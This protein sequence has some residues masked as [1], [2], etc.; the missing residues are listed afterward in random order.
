MRVVMLGL[1]ANNT[2]MINRIRAYAAE[3]RAACISIMHS[4]TPSFFAARELSGF[5]HWLAGQNKRKHAYGN[6][7]VEEFYVYEIDGKVVACA[8]FYVPDAE[9][10]A[11]LV[12]GMVH[13]QNHQQGIG[14]ELLAFGIHRIRELSP[15]DLITLD[16]TQHTLRFFKKFGFKIG[17]VQK[18]FYGVGLDRYDMYLK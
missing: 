8:G 2:R 5:E 15:Y 11:N 18:N 6:T 4:N 14:K 9:Q 16:T 10:R 1:I 13:R 7:K 12:W 17:K 3:D